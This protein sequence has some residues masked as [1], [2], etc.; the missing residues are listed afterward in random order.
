MKKKEKN[1]LRIDKKNKIDKQLVYNNYIHI[2]FTYSEKDILNYYYD[3]LIRLKDIGF[4]LFDISE[5]SENIKFKFPTISETQY[6]NEHDNGWEMIKDINSNIFNLANGEIILGYNNCA[7]FI[8]GIYRVYK[9]NNCLD[10]FFTDYANYFGSEYLVEQTTSLLTIVKMILY[11]YT[12]EEKQRKEKSFYSLINNDLRSGNPKKICRYL[13]MINNIYRLIQKNHLKSFNG[14]VYRAAYF[15]KELIEEIKSGKKMFNVSL[16]SSS[17]QKKVA[18]K[19]LFRY[20]KNILIHTHV[21]GISNIDIHLENLSRYPKE[22]EILILPFCC[23]EVKS[24]TK[25]REE[26]HEYYELELIFC[27]EENERNKIGDI[28]F[29]EVDYIS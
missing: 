20:K 28:E 29:E 18:K 4:I 7:K 5:I 10:L 27:Q 23:F 8:R 22:E 13:P 12:I 1:I 24:F 6:I 16:W 2:I 9:E 15:K 25:V 17:K 26:N 19:F 21:K 11:A 3:S 14:D